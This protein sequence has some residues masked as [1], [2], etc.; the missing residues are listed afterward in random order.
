VCAGNICRSPTAK[1]V[2][3]RLVAEADL[4]VEV[5]SAGTSSRGNEG[6]T[7]D[8]GSLVELV[9]HGL[10]G[11][12]HAARQFEGAMFADYDLVIALDTLDA[13]I[14]GLVVPQA[15]RGKVRLLTD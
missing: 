6:A 13:W 3:R 9:A 11:D 10:D 4:D 8:G 5:A 15:Y 12:G 2:L 7:I 14:L 1:R